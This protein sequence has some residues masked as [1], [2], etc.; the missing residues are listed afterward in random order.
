VAKNPPA[1]GKYKINPMDQSKR[2]FRQSPAWI[3]EIALMVL[4]L[5]GSGRGQEQNQPPTAPV[6]K[7]PPAQHAD[8]GTAEAKPENRISSK[9][10]EEL[11]QEVDEILQFVSKDT[12]FP[13]KH[14]VKRQLA[15]RDQVSAY[16]EKSLRE[17]KDAK[18]L[19]RTELVLKKF[20]LLPPDFEFEKSLVALLREQ[21]AGYYDQK[22]KTM[23]LLDWVPA[24]QQRSVLAHELTHAL[25]DQSFGLGKWLGRNAKDLD[26]KKDITPADIERDEGDETLEAVVE[27]QAEA[28][29]VDYLLEPAGRSVWNAPEVLAEL[30]ADMLKGDPGSVVFKNA[31]IFLKESLTFPYR[32]GVEFVAA[33]GQEGGKSKAFTGLFKNPPRTTRQIME[34][35]TYL[36]G[37]QIAPLPVPDLR[38]IFKNYERFDVG[39]MGE[40]DVSMLLDEYAGTE[41]SHSIYPYWRGGYYYAARPKSASNGPLGLLYVSR[42]ANPQ[43][44]QHFAAVYAKSLAKRYQHVQDVA[45]DGTN[46]AASFDPLRTWQGSR[47]WM[48]EQGAVVIEIEGTT[49]LVTESLDAATTE[50]LSHDVFAAG[51]Q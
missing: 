29:M 33:M 5:V 23:N 20:G 13:I 28:V 7:V 46:T 21:V 14:E 45:K 25:Q 22:S 48:S 39:A 47:Q 11:F 12:A 4:V 31:P 10:A 27:G 36:S 35:K 16:L 40:F 6:A 8:A 9:D 50:R 34:P 3:R 17:D 32:Y 38:D 24:E 1:V 2:A 18:R 41:V 51:Q 42:W 37:E 26:K 19:R 43:V 49:V 15:S 30:D 44:A